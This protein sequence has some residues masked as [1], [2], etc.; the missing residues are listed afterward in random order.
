MK[1]TVL[2]AMAVFVIGLLVAGLP[3]ALAAKPQNVIERSNGYPS[4]AHFNLNIHGKQDGFTCD[5]TSGGGSV[6]VS[7]YGESTIE[8]VSNKKA[9]LTELKVLDCCAECFDG[10]PAKVQLPSEEQGYYVFARIHGKPNNG[11]KDGDPSSVILYPNPVLEVCNDDPANPDPAFGDYT[12]PND[13]LWALG[14]VTTRGIYEATEAGFVRFDDTADSKGKGKS[15]AKDITGLFTWTGWVCDASLDTSGPD[16]VPDGVIDAYDV[17]AEYDLLTYGGNENGIIDP[18]E[19][20]NW[21]ADQEMAGNC[22][23]YES[24][25][26]FNVADLVVQ[27]QTISNDGAKLLQVRFYPVA[28]TEFTR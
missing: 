21:L 23:Y 6:F 22:T 28:T 24:E 26:V 9:S 8:Y 17:P 14:L 1:K 25:W 13:T 4:G 18:A 3:T 5:A 2:C 19:L 10:D 12:D 11:A 20:E 16:G 15:N 27:S 7:E